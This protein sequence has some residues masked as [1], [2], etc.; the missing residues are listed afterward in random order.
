M[1]NKLFFVRWFKLHGREFPWRNEAV[2]PFQFLVTE[3]LL[4]QT[5]APSVAKIW[6]RF[7][8]K[9]PGASALAR[10][11]KDSLLNLVKVLGFGNQ[12]SSALRL[13]ASYLVKHHN[14]DVPTSVE[15]LLK[16]PHV[17]H[18]AAHA[19]MCFAFGHRI[20]IVDT[21]IQRFFAR[22]YGLAVKPD[23][24]QNKWL[25]EIAREA[26]PGKGE[27]AKQHNFG[28]LDFTAQICK[29]GRPLCEICPLNT[30]CEF[31]KQ[32]V[33]LRDNAHERKAA[34]CRR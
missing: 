8:D 2:T 3:M 16:V 33:T 7:F 28:L 11:R 25:W 13:A 18:Y 32:R 22:Y 27:K 9:Y 6:Y 1:L 34:L 5:D 31:G 12:R 21:N 23:T 24:R 19:V 10:A 14:G 26:I 20:E 29:A 17:G 30:S 15:E 4:R